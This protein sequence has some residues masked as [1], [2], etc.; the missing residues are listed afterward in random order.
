MPHL[1]LGSRELDN[2]YP[3]LCVPQE[4]SEDLEP[5]WDSWD[6]VQQRGLEIIEQIRTTMRLAGRRRYEHRNGERL[7]DAAHGGLCQTAADP[8]G[9]TAELPRCLSHT[10]NTTT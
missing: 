1:E 8:I 3:S 2:E 6:R 7:H 5:E 9:F 10:A 4:V